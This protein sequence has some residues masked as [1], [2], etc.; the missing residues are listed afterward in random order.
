[1]C[2][3]LKLKLLPLALVL[4][5]T[6]HCHLFD[7]LVRKCTVCMINCSS[8]LKKGIFLPMIMIFVLINI[9]ADGNI[10]RV[11]KLLISLRYIFLDTLYFII[12]GLFVHGF[13]VL[14]L[15]FTVVTRTLPF[16]FIANMTNAITTAFGTASSSAT[17]PVTISLLEEKNK[18]D[19]RICR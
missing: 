14:P 11:K 7:P 3:I 4:I 16:K 13:V 10:I 2:D 18:V 8:P 6:K 1:M 17:L 19:P 12:S 9:G 5:K 15:V